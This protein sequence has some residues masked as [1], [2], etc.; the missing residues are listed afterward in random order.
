MTTKTPKKIPLAAG[1]LKICLFWK[2]LE[3]DAEGAWPIA[4]ALVFGLLV[5]GRVSLARDHS[6]ALQNCPAIRRKKL[7]AAEIFRRESP[8]QKSHPFD[9]HLRRSR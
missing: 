7:S 2:V 3:V 1:R 8:T 4:G 5:L 9:G 6:V